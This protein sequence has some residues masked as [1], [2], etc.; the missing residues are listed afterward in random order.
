MKCAVCKYD[1]GFHFIKLNGLFFDDGQTV[2]EAIACPNCR[3]V[4]VRPEKNQDRFKNCRCGWCGNTHNSEFAIKK[5]KLEVNGNEWEN[6]NVICSCGA[7]G[8]DE[9]SEESAIGAYRR[10]MQNVFKAE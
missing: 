3:T 8:P 2:S 7:S 6:F 5:E 10:G 1:V 4:M 9:K